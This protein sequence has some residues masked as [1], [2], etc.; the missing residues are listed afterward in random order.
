MK[1]MYFHIPGGCRILSHALKVPAIIVYRRL[2][3]IKAKAL[4]DAPWRYRRQSHTLKMKALIT[5]LKVLALS[6]HLEGADTAC[7]L[8]PNPVSAGANR[9][10]RDAGANHPFQ[11]VSMKSAG[12]YLVP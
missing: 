4:I 9:N 5:Y 6:A 10:D 2:H 11:V 1:V 12:T 3:T 7:H 8:A